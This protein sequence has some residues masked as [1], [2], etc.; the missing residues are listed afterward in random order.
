[1][2]VMRFVAAV[3]G[4]VRFAFPGPAWNPGRSLT[5]VL[6]LLL[7]LSPGRSAAEA[8]RAT[9]SSGAGASGAGAAVDGRMDTRWVSNY[10]DHEWWQAEF[11]AP[12]MLAGLRIAWEAAYAEQ[13]Q[14]AVSLD[15]RNWKTVYG[16]EDGDGRTDLLFLHPTQARFVRI[17]CTR[18]GT[19]WGYSIWEVIFFDAAQAP[20]LSVSSARPE[21]GPDRALDGDPATAWG[22]AAGG[23]QTLALE[24]P[25]PFNLG[26][27]ELVWG[28]ARPAAYSLATSMDGVEWLAAG[29]GQPGAAG[30]RD[31]VFFPA[32]T[33]RFFRVTGRGG[34]ADGYALAE[35]ELKGGEERPLPLREY[36]AQAQRAPAGLYPMWLARRQEYWTVVG[37][38]DGEQ[39]MLCGETG[40]IE[41][42]K[43]DFSIV[44]AVW[45]NGALV[46]YTDVRLEQRLAEGFLPVPTVTWRAAGWR[47][48]IEP[49]ATGAAGATLGVVRYRF[50]NDG[51]TAFT[52][53][54]MLIVRPIQLNPVWQSGG[55]SPIRRCEAVLQPRPGELRI[56]GRSAIFLLTPPAAARACA[57]GA[58]DVLEALLQPEAAGWLPAEDAEGRI[59]AGAV[60]KLDVPAG[61]AREVVIACRMD[62]GAKVPARLAAQPEAV[63]AALR[64]QVKN[65]WWRVLARPEITIPERRL[66]DVMKSNIGYVMINRDA[67]WFKPGTRNYN[68]AW[69]R[70]G[71]LSSAAML[72]MGHPELARRFIEAFRDCIAA[73]G[74]VPFMIME[75]GRPCRFNPGTDGEG[76]EYDSQGQFAFLVRQYYDFTGDRELAGQVY[77]LVAR[78]LRYAQ[79]LRQR[80]LTAEYA[81]TAIYGILPESNSH[82]GYFPARHSYWD[83]FWMLKGLKDGAYLAGRLGATNDLGWM[84]AEEADLRRSLLA[85][86]QAVMAR[87]RLEYLPGCVELG[88]EDPTSTAIAVMA[89]DEAG[90][91]PAAQL[92]RTFDRYY[93][94]IARRFSGAAD[95]FTPY[96]A[97]NIDV[98]VRLGRRERALA[99]ARYLTEVGTR[100]RDWNQLAEVVHADP[101]APA[102]IGDMPHTWVGADYINAIRSLFVYEERGGLALAAGVDPQWLQAG[103]V[104]VKDLPTPFGAVSYRFAENAGVARL[105]VS[106]AA[107]PPDGFRLP[108]PAELAGR[109]ATVNGAPAVVEDQAIRFPTLPAEIVLK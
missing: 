52:G 26:G 66:I 5:R 27:V 11:P 62:D 54:L 25:E 88:D 108:L 107:A 19:G 15:G 95:T 63:S 82:E 90:E 60:Y 106:G 103:G 96:E 3:D 97:R 71:A 75:D 33:A 56:N 2:Q 47:L 43:G 7:V 45:A 16:V 28:A 17:N 40:V 87:D 53:R 8:I 18:R 93:D 49:I 57:M 80:R 84:R 51:A 102:Y 73:S 77:P 64:A 13:Y 79:A 92:K 78:A 68:H 23:A 9:A 22:T 85:S 94:R 69:L 39:E 29:D 89:C 38:P 41:P 6:V 72:R 14:V 44:P 37:A 36:R 58:G 12:R 70:D 105:S 74:W 104:T 21:A 10:T 32:R 42:R 98:F 24:L 76:Q 86:M 99:L 50:C 67:P 100:P 20:R 35:L 65:G 101:R 4:T 91:L 81:G 83:D 31:V 61:G 1:M 55:F 109:V 30:A 34:P 48:E 59:S 46:T